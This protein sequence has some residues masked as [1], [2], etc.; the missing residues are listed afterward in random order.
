MDWTKTFWTLIK[1]HNFTNKF[2]RFFYT[3]EFLFRLFDKM[4]SIK[5]L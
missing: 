4:V 1:R 2:D 3:R 5:E